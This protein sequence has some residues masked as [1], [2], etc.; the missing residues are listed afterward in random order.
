[1]YVELKSIEE[2]IKKMDYKQKLPRTCQDIEVKQ[3]T[4]SMNTLG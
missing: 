3:C 4:T 1:M 2:E